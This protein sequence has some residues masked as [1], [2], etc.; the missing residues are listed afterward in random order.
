[1]PCQLVSPLHGAR[2][3]G[4]IVMSFEG[5]RVDTAG[6]VQ[7]A[8]GRPIPR[9]YAGGAAAAGLSGGTA[10]GDLSGAGLLMSPVLGLLVSTHLAGA[11]PA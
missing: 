2:V 10:D 11:E 1:M 4:G 6:R 7:G 3:T 8:D 9:P 5:V